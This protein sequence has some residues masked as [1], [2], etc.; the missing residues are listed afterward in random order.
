MHPKYIEPVPAW[1]ILGRTQLTGNAASTDIITIP[2]RDIIRITCIVT[3]YTGGGI[4]SLRF[5]GTAGAVDSGNN[6]ATLHATGLNGSNKWDNYTS[7][8]NTSLLR[9]A[10]A[11]ST[12]GRMVNV[13]V[14]NIASYRKICQINVANE[15]GGAGTVNQLATGQGIWANTTNQ[16]VSVQMISTANQLRTDSGFIVEGIKLR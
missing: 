10:Q 13:Q 7:S 11:N 16:I 4:A 8:V 3:G 12:L 1:E 9:L 5:G 15:I 2:A 14:M 6:Y